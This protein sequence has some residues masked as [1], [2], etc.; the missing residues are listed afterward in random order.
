M[1][2][3]IDTYSWQ[4]WSRPTRSPILRFAF[5]R[6]T[7]PNIEIQFVTDGV[8]VALAD[9]SATGTLGFKT[10]KTDAS[11]LVAP[12]SWT[13]S[14]TGTATKYTFTPTFLASN[15]DTALGS[16]DSIVVYGEIKWVD[17]SNT[18]ETGFSGR[19]YSNLNRG[20]ES[21]PSTPE[22]YGTYTVS[23]TGSTDISAAGGLAVVDVTAQAG[24]GVYTYK[25]VLLTTGITA[26]AKVEINIH[27]AASANPTIDI[28]NAT[29]G[30][31]SLDAVSGD[32][33]NATNYHFE[34]RFNGTAW[35]QTEGDWEI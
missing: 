7:V 11:Y 1:R 23:A 29:S 26:P 10:A 4:I 24:S 18:G 6:G 22:A 8:V 14:G 32:S 33:S 17:G 25:F 16:N 20:G 12:V 2:Y 35:V 3:Y 19:I 28:R 5:D 31:T 34:A 21:V 27:L 9:G 15:L 13:K 30:G